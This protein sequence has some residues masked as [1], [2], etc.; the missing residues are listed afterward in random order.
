MS[1]P[2]ASR[3]PSESGFT[4]TEMVAGLLVASLVVTGIVE[5]TGR[6]ATTSVRIREATKA[7]A[8]DRALAAIAPML[9]RADPRSVQLSSDRIEARIGARTVTLELAQ[10]T[11]TGST[12]RIGLAGQE[13]MVELASSVW[14]QLSPGGEIQIMRDD[15][16]APIVALRPKRDVPYDCQYDVVSRSCR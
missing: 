4:L 8:G 5:L 10:S 16:S 6:Y 14:F 12:I 2:P 3:I 7:I 1:P 15:Q 9:E 13:R 11:V